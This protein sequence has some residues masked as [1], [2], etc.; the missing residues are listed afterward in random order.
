M[1]G[2]PAPCPWKRL[3][4]SAEGVCHPL[5]RQ[6]SQERSAIWDDALSSP[7]GLDHGSVLAVGLRTPSFLLEPHAWFELD[8]LKALT[9]WA[10]GVRGSGEGIEGGGGFPSGGRL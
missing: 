3:S 7:P 4:L 10:G 1:A 6:R 9:R 2:G 5:H 8:M